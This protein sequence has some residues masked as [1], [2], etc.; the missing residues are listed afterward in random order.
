MSRPGCN[1]KKQVGFL[2]DHLTA[3]T[4]MA[5]CHKHSYK[6]N[7][8]YFSYLHNNKK[9]YAFNAYVSLNINQDRWHLALCQVDS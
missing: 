6:E 5:H 7:Y 2:I 9:I 3:I 1:T 4:C 8:F